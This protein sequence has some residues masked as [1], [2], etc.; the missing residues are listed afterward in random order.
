MFLKQ[1][2]RNSLSLTTKHDKGVFCNNFSNIYILY[3]TYLNI[4]IY[5]YIYIYIHILKSTSCFVLSFDEIT[6]LVV[7][8]EF[9]VSSI[10]HLINSDVGL[11]FKQ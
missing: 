6:S 10:C 7:Q 8:N 2:E 9:N 4:Y 11:F 3:I 5:I 1:E